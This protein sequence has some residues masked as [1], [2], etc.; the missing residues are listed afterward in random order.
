MKNVYSRTGRIQV[1]LKPNDGVFFLRSMRQ[2]VDTF[3]Q[4]MKVQYYGHSCFAVETAGKTLL[5]DPFISGNELARTVDV[6]R[7]PADYILVSHGHYDHVGDALPIARRTGAT[8]ISNFEVVTWLAK[9]GVPKTHPL[10]HGGACHFDFGRV[11][12]VNAIHSSSLPDGSY[13]GNPGGFVVESADGN[14]Y[15]SGDTALTM[16]MKLIGEATRLCFAALPLGDNFTM[17]IADAIKAADF[18]R[19]NQVLGLH[20]NT[21]APIQINSYDAEARFKAAGK[22]LHLLHPG[23]VRDLR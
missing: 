3:S 23:E 11:K 1:G 20:Y 12:F 17:G 21:F 10:N 15:F 9:Q 16:D 22:Q 18:V 2:G 5:F 13:G 7:V 4:R 14:F 8:V 6:G 19:C